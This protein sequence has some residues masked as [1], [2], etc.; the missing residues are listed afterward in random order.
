MTF[1]VETTQFAVIELSEDEPSEMG[2]LNRYQVHL[3]VI[4]GKR[5]TSYIWDAKVSN[6]HFFMIFYD[7]DEIWHSVR[8]IVQL[9][10]FM[11]Y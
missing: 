10:F 1:E 8:Q 6:E 3:G 11:L 4:D 9:F 7:N 2:N 5:E